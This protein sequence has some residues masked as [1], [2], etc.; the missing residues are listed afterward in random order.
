MSQG[1][2][3]ALVLG[4]ENFVARKLVERLRKDEI[5]VIMDDVESLESGAVRYFFDFEGRGEA[6]EKAGANN[7]KTTVVVVNDEKK[8]KEIGERMGIEGGDI[9]LVA[10]FGVYGPRMEGNEII[11]KAFESAVKNKNLVLPSLSLTYRLLAVDDLV[12][13][14]LRASFIS[15]TAGEFFLVEGEEINSQE[16]AKTLIEAAKMTKNQV[17]QN[18]I[19]VELFDK[20][21]ILDNWR[22]LRWRPEIEFKDGIEETLQYFFVKVDEESRRKKDHRSL[23]VDRGSESK[24]AVAKAMAGKRRFEVEVEEGELIT[25]NQIPITKQIP[26]INEKQIT[27]QEDGEK[28]V[29]EADEPADA[30]AMA[31]EPKF[32]IK[33]IIKKQRIEPAVP[34]AAGG[35]E[36]TVEEVEDIKSPSPAEQGLSPLTKGEQKTKQPRK[37]R[38]WVKWVVMAGILFLLYLPVKWGISLVSLAKTISKSEQLIKTSKF[39]QAVAIIDK[40]TKK[41]MANEEQIT[42][43]GLNRIGIFR[44]IQE[45]FRMGKSVLNL[46]KKAVEVG[47]QTVVL[48]EGL[49]GDEKVSWAFELNKLFQLLLGFEEEIGMLEARVSGN[50]KW[51]PKRFKKDIDSQLKE[52][53]KTRENITILR[54]FFPVIPELIGT[55]GKRRE[56]LVLLQN[57]MELRATGGF[58]GSFGI[59]GFQDGKMLNFEI[60]DVYDADG[61]MEG[62]VE[63]PSEIKEYL[64]EAA[65]FLRDAN[66]Q[67]DFVGAAKDLRWFLEKEIGRKVDGVIGMN[68]AVAKAILG[69]VGEVTVPDYKEKINEGNLYEQAEF[70]SEDKFFPGSGQKASFLSGLGKQLFEEIKDMNSEKRLKLM[71]VLIEKLA[72]NEMQIALNNADSAQIIASL[73]WDG[74]IKEGKCATERCVADYT[75]VNESNFGVNKANYFILREIEKTVEIGSSRLARVLKINYENTAKSMNY[76][77][78]NYRN[79]LR[80][81]LPKDINLES[82]KIIDG[83]NKSNI[84]TVEGDK[85]KMEEKYGKKELGFLVTVPV[86]GKKTVEIKYFSEITLNS[87]TFSYLDYIQRQPGSGKTDVVVMVGYPQSYQP[88]QVEPVATV[89]GDKIVFETKLERDLKIGVEVG[90]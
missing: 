44:N 4:C 72:E 6:W 64:G 42:E 25:N 16:V 62:H 63:P 24:P 17:I 39:D 84:E 20:N 41:V 76:P 82:I 71:E 61:Q 33:P 23:I 73:G 78:G 5:E 69:V 54:H 3:V 53:I 65:W 89:E 13:A 36:E 74:S 80:V 29:E 10:A 12:E 7:T 9:R 58:I 37:K 50:A 11:A 56:Y 87:D 2:P 45:I 18:E 75:Y 19:Q 55:D 60:K 38:R 14:I 59:L 51:L 57:E 43:F 68:L 21:V 27:K 8:T 22:K 83:E 26:I 90:R 46:E 31:D 28:V 32:E 34:A 86:S 15:G 48:N 77:G 52:L 1:L 79:Y 81:Y 70:Y 49:F 66:W 85:L 40:Q 67:A 35:K 88:M 30:K 47:E